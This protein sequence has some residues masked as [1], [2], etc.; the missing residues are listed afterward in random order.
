[1]LEEL[2]VNVKSDISFKNL[3]YTVLNVRFTEFLR[4]PIK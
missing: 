2:Y 1:M 4:F 3:E